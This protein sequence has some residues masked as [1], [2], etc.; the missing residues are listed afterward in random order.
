MKTGLA[1]KKSCFFKKS[2]NGN[3]PPPPTK[4]K[5]KIFSYAVFS[6]LDTL[7]YE[8]G[9]DRLSQNVSNELPLYV[10]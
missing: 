2:D 5:K 7:T 6:P 4:K 9:A 8:D 3:P 1:S 10:V